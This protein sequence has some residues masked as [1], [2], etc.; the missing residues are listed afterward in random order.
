MGTHP[1][2]E[3]DFDCLTGSCA[4]S[5]M[6]NTDA[7]KVIRQVEYYFGDSNMQRDKFLL[8]EVAKDAEGWVPLSTMLKFKR[9]GDLVNG[10]AG[11][12]VSS[13]KE[14]KS[15][16]VEIAS[17]ESKI[18]RNPE[19]K[20]PAFDD[21]YKRQQ[22]AR[23]CYVKG[24]AV[25]ETLDALQDYFDAY[26]LESVFMR[27]VPL[28][29]QFKGSVFVTF[30]T[31]QNCDDFMNETETKY[32]EETLIKMTKAAYYES[33]KDEQK[34]G[35]KQKETRHGADETS[36]EGA[37]ERIVK[38]S[39]VTDDTVGR[40]EILAKI[41]TEVK[42]QVDF[43]CFERGK[44]EGLVLLKKPLVAKEVIEKMADNPVAILGAEKV[45][46]VALDGDEAQKAFRVLKDDREALF[47]RLKNKKGGKGGFKG[48]RGGFNQRAP[49]NKRTKFDDEEPVEK[50]AKDE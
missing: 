11:S 46:F 38:F 20:V 24:F 49:K 10:E 14:S 5:K 8:D 26:S 33:K 45:E 32:K 39:G 29:K 48:N 2:F 25:D 17:D 27:R 36:D 30:K 3:S 21:N 41:V 37:M 9:L 42:E 7:K 40:E 12:I 22:K 13:L 50:K 31:Q 47:A 6:T 1:I 4:S 43:T 15:N 18:R 23:T 34:P 44:T 16:L 28:S 19:L 35:R